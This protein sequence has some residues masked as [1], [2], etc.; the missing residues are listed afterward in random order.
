MSERSR[1]ISRLSGKVGAA[2]RWQPK[3][4]STAV[5]TDELAAALER[6]YNDDRINALVASGQPPTPAQAGLLLG[7]L[8]P[9]AAQPGTRRR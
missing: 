4:D 9:D 1:E 3:A 7:W 6:S 8:D 5:L 2:R